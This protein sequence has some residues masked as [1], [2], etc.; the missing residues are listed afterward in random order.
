MTSVFRQFSQFFISGK[1]NGYSSEYHICKKK[2]H[3]FYG[4]G[5]HILEYIYKDICLGVFLPT[6]L[7]A[8]MIS[9]GKFLNEISTSIMRAV[10]SLFDH[11]RIA[12]PGFALFSLC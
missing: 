4:N 6:G 2:D 8:K 3:I 10:V 1:E 9:P 5:I 11:T 7:S 12:Q